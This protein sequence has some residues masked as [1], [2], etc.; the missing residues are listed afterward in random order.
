MDA[1][2]PPV[3]AYPPADFSTAGPIKVLTLQ[4]EGSWPN[5]PKNSAQTGF[6]SQKVK[7]KKCGDIS[8]SSWK[9]KRCVYL[10]K[11]HIE[12]HAQFFFS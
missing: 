10:I 12:I 3:R 7:S 5:M 4:S 11:K 6:M 2:S 1:D 9:M 8:K